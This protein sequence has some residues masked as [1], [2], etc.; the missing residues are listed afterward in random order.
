MVDKLWQLNHVDTLVVEALN[1]R[2]ETM[3]NNKK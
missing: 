1:G 3:Q 2:L